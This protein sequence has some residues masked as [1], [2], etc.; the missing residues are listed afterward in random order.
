MVPRNGNTINFWNDVWFSDVP[1]IDI[2]SSYKRKEINVD[3]KTSDF[4]NYN[5]HWNLNTLMNILPKNIIH[6]IRNTPIPIK[7]IEDKIY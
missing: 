5:K 7:D 2:V 1:I 3:A 4:I 6:M